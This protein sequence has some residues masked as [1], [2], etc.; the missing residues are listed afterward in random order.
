M[1]RDSH[2]VPGQRILRHKDQRCCR[3]L[4]VRVKQKPGCRQVGPLQPSESFTTNGIAPHPLG[5]TVVDDQVLERP[6]RRSAQALPE[7]RG[8]WRSGD[9]LTAAEQQEQ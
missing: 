7:N 3:R 5:R 2:L 1:V 4:L 6:E 9:V 8:G